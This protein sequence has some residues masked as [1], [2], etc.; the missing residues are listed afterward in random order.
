[1]KL[2]TLQTIHL[3]FCIFIFLFA[4][5][6]LLV[7]KNILFFDA[8]FASSAPFNPIFPA[9]AIIAIALGTIMFNK[10]MAS[11]T[12]VQPLEFKFTQYQVAF[13]IRCAFFEAGALLNI[14]GFFNTYN[15]F[16]ILFA[17]ASFVALL[18]SR[19]TKDKVISALQL[20]YP[21]TE[22]L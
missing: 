10:K 3:A 6:A 15:L 20:Q 4:T 19:P 14:V 11:I 17:A 5:V 16:F 18:L 12:P 1:M 13:L 2:K 9:V 7:N 21:D 8:S 22:N